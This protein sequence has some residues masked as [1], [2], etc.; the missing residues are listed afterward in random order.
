MTVAFTAMAADDGK[1]VA[2]GF[3]KTLVLPIVDHLVS[4]TFFASD[5]STCDL[6]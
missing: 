1:T 3:Y 5:R 6:R 4:T 2:T